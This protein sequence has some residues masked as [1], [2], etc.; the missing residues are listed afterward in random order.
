[1]NGDG[2]MP[3]GTYLRELDA[4]VRRAYASGAGL[5]DAMRTVQ[6]PAFRHDKLYTI[7]QP[8]NV[9]RLY[10]QLEKLDKQ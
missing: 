4:A 9:Q 8:Q 3:T 5:T 6:V 7:A 10:L 1:V 2:I